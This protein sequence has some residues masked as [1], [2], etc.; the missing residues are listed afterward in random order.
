MAQVANFFDVMNLNALLTRQGIAAE[1]HLRDACGRQ[2]LWFELQ[3]DATD[4]LAKAQNAATT[5]FAS[6]GKMI[7]FD[8]AKGLNFWIK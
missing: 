1:I 6:K 2:T 7:E 4:T 8:I 3:D 5:Y